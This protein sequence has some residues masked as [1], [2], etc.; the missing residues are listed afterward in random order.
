MNQDLLLERKSKLQLG[1]AGYAFSGG[2]RRN[3]A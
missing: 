3:F 1:L 2:S